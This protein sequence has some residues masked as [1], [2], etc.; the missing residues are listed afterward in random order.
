MD[1]CEY[2]AKYGLTNQGTPDL[3]E[4]AT[5]APIKHRGTFCSSAKCGGQNY[6]NGK[7][8]AAGERYLNECP[9]CGSKMVV[10]LA[11]SINQVN[12]MNFRRRKMDAAPRGA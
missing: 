3:S 7:L 6:R 4:L 1:Q 9:N 10:H 5:A 11:V 8:V 2:L 12:L